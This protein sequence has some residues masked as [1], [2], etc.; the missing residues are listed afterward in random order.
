MK[1]HG[2][3]DAYEQLKAL[4]RGQAI[5]RDSLNSFINTLD[6]PEAARSEL[7]GLTP[8]NYTGFADTLATH[9]DPY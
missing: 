3:E 1:R 7:A 2:I 6:I 8:Q 9:P 5:T 4:T